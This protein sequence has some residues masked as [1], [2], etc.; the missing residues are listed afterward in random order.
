M[1][2]KTHFRCFECFNLRVVVRENT[3]APILKKKNQKQ[4]RYPFW[5]RKHFEFCFVNSANFKVIIF[6]G[7][8][9][10]IRLVTEPMDYCSVFTLG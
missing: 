2:R 8:M 3:Y 4:N 1:V 7:D 10:F 5:K 6:R 9:V